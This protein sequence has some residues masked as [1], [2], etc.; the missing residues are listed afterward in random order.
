MVPLERGHGNAYTGTWAPLCIVNDRKEF[1]PRV[2]AHQ[3]RGE[4]L[5]SYVQY[6]TLY[7]KSYAAICNSRSIRLAI[8]DLASY[9]VNE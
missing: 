9:S 5:G 7:S 6:H 4:S 1:L 3:S 8:D 2:A